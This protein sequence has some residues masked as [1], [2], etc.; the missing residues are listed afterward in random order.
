MC[1]ESNHDRKCHCCC[2]QGPQGIPGPQGSQGIQGQ[3]GPQGPQ[4]LQGIQGPQGMQ[5]IQGEPGKDCDCENMN[6]VYLN[7]Y[8]NVDQ[9]IT[10]NGGVSDYVKFSS[11]NSITPP[12]FDISMANVTGVIKCLTAGTYVIHWTADGML[13]PPFPSPVPS[14]ALALYKNNVVIPGSAQAGFSQSPDD[15]AICLSGEVIIIIASGDELKLLNVSTLPIFLKAVHP[16]LVVPM[17]SAS[18]AIHK[19]H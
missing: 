10:A 14:W 6:E 19:I 11:T 2:L 9:S 12:D 15:D 1:Y 18:I 17:T 13:Q 5:G 4:G 3:I 7:M 8:S 16:E